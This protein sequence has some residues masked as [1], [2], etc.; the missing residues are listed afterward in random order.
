[1]NPWISLFIFC[2]SRIIYPRC[3]SVS[4][5][6]YFRLDAFFV[7]LYLCVPN[8]DIIFWRFLLIKNLTIACINKTNHNLYQMWIYWDTHI[9]NEN[10][11]SV[12]VQ[13]CQWLGR[14]WPGSLLAP[15]EFKYRYYKIEKYLYWKICQH[16]NIPNAENA[17][18]WKCYIH[19]D[20]TIHTDRIMQVYGPGIVRKAFKNRTAILKTWPFHLIKA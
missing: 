1:M 2:A 14:I 12:N 17:R 18:M 6:T 13:G 16:Y 20:F 8:K 9:L 10:E 19:W 11:L 4:I 15:S 3:T 7:F 5:Y